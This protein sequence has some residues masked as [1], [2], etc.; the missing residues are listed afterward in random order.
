MVIYPYAIDQRR[1]FRVI[2]RVFCVFDLRSSDGATDLL[3]SDDATDLLSSDDATQQNMR[4]NS[5]F[6]FAAPSVRCSNIY[7]CAPAS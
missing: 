4:V 2:F 7:R 6:A 1:G 3:S 5:L